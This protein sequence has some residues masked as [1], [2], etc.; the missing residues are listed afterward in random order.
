MEITFTNQEYLWLLLS[1]PV[2]ILI[3]FWT[4][5]FSKKKAINFANFEAL[6]RVTGK[7]LFSKNITILV[8]RIFVLLTLIFSITGTTL[9]YIG[10]S[11]ENSYVLAIDASGSML[12][13]DFSPNRLEAAKQ[14][15]MLFIDELEAKTRIG[16]V[17][18]SGISYIEQEITDDLSK[19]KDAIKNIEIKPTH[20]TA[21]G[22]ALLTSSNLL[23]GEKNSKSVI[24]LTDGRENVATNSE[25]KRVIDY[26]IDKHI[27]IIPIGV[28]T[29]RGGKLPGI[30]AVSSIDESKLI[31]IAN[32]TRGNYFRARDKEELKKIYSKIAKSKES[33]IPFELRIPFMLLAVLLLFIEWMLA[34]T[35]YRIIP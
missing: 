2:L 20:G 23:L 10:K 5:K 16:V 9:W 32:K 18:F 19:V 25:F 29:E 11:L 1:I 22:E 30:E 6:R 33:K 8:I 12:A 31:E 34:N 24:L 7:Y 27:I 21:L 28:A 13:N 26:V 17:S 14:A 15:A 4:L 35:R 3:H